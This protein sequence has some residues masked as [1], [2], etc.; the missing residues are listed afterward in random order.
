MLANRFAELRAGGSSRFYNDSHSSCHG[1]GAI[2]LA[3]DRPGE[4]AASA[5]AL[6]S[7]QAAGLMLE[8][9][10]GC[11]KPSLPVQ[12]VVVRKRVLYTGPNRCDLTIASES[13]RLLFDWT[14][15]AKLDAVIRCT[16]RLKGSVALFIDGVAMSVIAVD[17]EASI[18]TTVPFDSI[19]LR[20]TV[21]HKRRQPPSLLAR[22]LPVH[23]P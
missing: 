3:Y 13:D 14:D 9:V 1:R 23:S 4:L 22:E 11:A 5:A 21:T 8:S 7:A 18:L 2:L 16:H 10:A 6:S 20:S 15:S 12:L 19:G 17:L